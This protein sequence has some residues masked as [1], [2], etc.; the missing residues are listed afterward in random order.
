MRYQQINDSQKKE[1]HQYQHEMLVEKE[2]WQKLM[3]ELENK[4]NLEIEA[5]RFKAQKDGE[6][7]EEVVE[8]LRL[9]ID[10]LKAEKDQLL[11]YIEQKNQ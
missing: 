4:K 1:L 9:D 10:K 11:D 6:K 8:S 2:Q 3:A 7:R 5:G